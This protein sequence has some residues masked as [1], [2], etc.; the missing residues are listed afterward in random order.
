[1]AKAMVAFLK[2]DVR[3]TQKR[4]QYYTNFVAS[5]VE[6]FVSQWLQANGSACGRSLG[7]EM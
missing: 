1:M 5:T 7:A 3:N 4:K 2:L 6:A